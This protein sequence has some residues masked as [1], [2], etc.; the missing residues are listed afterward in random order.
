M[1]WSRVV[2]TFMSDTKY[3]G[4]GFAKPEDVAILPKARACFYLKSASPL[5]VHSCV[6]L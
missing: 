6:Q 1:A 3:L 2:S 4:E 5:G